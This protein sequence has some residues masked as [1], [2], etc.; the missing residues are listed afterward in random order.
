MET[1]KLDKSNEISNVPVDKYLFM[2]L[3][4]PTLDSW[5]FFWRKI[6]S[7]VIIVICLI[8]TI[9]INL[10][11]FYVENSQIYADI[12]SPIGAEEIREIS[13]GYWLYIIPVL[14]FFIREFMSSIYRNIA[15]YLTNTEYH[16]HR[17]EYKSALLLKILFFEFFN[18]YFNL[19]YIA[20]VKRYFEA[21]AFNDCYGEVANQLTGILTSAIIVDSTRVFWY[22]IHQRNKLK[23]FENNIKE[24]NP[25]LSNR[26]SKYIYYTRV[27]Y[28]SE[29]AS[30]EYLDI[31]MNYGYIIQFGS[32]SPICFFIAL[33]QTIFMRMIDAIK[34]SKLQYVRLISNIINIIYR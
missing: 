25:N 20:F 27:E 5:I 1:F 9:I 26:S 23:E 29:D 15:R 10:L 22:A 18:Y 2:G 21:C 13:N 33:L 28:E 12:D 32:S 17:D 3:Y 7:F 19:Y 16:I 11:L 30:G 6:F 14:T 4:M 24:A 34:M 31:V 8:I